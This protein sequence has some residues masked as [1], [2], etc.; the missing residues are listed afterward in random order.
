MDLT[1]RIEKGIALR[2]LGG[3]E[4]VRRVG[5]VVLSLIWDASERGCKGVHSRPMPLYLCALTVSG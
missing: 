1:L 3:V 4:E 5:G 2:W